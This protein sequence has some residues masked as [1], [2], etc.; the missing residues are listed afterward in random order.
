MEYQALENSLNIYSK[1][2]KVNQIFEGVD[3]HR[4]KDDNFRT[5]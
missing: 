2:G 5:I 1:M 4:T 3:S